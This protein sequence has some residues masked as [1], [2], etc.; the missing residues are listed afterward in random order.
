MSDTVAPPATVTLPNG[1]VIT[2]SMSPVER[3]NA[4]AASIGAAPVE[5]PPPPI[6]GPRGHTD[7]TIAEFN[8]RDSAATKA[9]PPAAPAKVVVP[10]QG[11]P[12][13]R[14][15]DSSG[16]FT[17]AMPTAPQ[18]PNTEYMELLKAVYRDTP[19]ASSVRPLP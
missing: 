19:V 11:S 16:R 12:E 17:P 3:H 8:R 4:V 7:A 9:P 5:R 15:R 18:T 10:P 14:A 13:E 1:A 2:S 6:F